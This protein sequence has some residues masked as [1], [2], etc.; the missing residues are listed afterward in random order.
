MD[1]IRVIVRG[2]ATDYGAFTDLAARVCALVDENEPS[3]LGYECFVDESSA[4]FLWYE[5]YADDSAFLKHNQNL[6]E[7]GIMDEVA[8]VVQFDNVTALGDVTGAEARE[9]LA[10]W[11]AAVFQPLTGVV[12]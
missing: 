8:Q 3:T 11:G 6:A 9:A 4:Q 12:R 2:T 7:A 5:V 10:Q 1:T